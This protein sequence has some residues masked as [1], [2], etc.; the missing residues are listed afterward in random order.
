MV[1]A[2]HVLPAIDLDTPEKHE[3][4]YNQENET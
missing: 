4:D 1:P 2:V 3:D